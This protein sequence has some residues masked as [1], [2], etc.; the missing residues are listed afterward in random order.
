MVRVWLLAI[1]QSLRQKGYVV[2]ILS[3]QCQWLEEPDASQ[4]FLGEFDRVFVSYKLGKGKRDPSLFNDVV[5][6]LGIEP[7]EILF[8]DDDV[9][10]VQHAREHGLQALVYHDRGHLE[11]DLETVLGMS[12]KLA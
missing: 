9:G 12:T 5:R 11:A 10:N 1:A 3:G 2:G 4:R 7:Q 6:E 8:I